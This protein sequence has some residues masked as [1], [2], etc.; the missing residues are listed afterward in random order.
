MDRDYLSSPDFNFD[1]IN[2]ASKACGPL[3]SW[4]LAQMRYSTLLN[5]VDPLRQEIKEL[6]KNAEVKQ[7]EA[8]DLAEKV[9]VL[10]DQ[11]AQYK[12]DYSKLMAK[13][14]ELK[15]EME[16]VQVSI[17][18]AKQ[19]VN[20]LSGEHERWEK[21]SASFTE[22]IATVVGDSLISAGF[23][24]YLG[25]YNH[26]FRE[27]LVTRWR[28][29][30]GELGID[31]DPRLQLIQ[32]LSSP[33]QRLHW[34]QAELP[35][36]SLCVENAI[37]LS[38]FNRYPLLVDPAGQGSQFLLQNPRENKIIRTSF[39]DGTFLKNLESSM[40]FG[41]ALLIDDVESLDPILNPVLNRE[42]QKVGGRQLVK[43]ADKDI[44]FNP[45]FSIFLC[46][47]DPFCD[48]TPDLC[49]RVTFVNFA[50]T[51]ASL[52]SQCLSKILRAE[53]PAVDKTRTDQLKLQGEFKVRLRELED[54]LLDALNSIAGNILDDENV[55]TTLE[56][57]KSESEKIKVMAEETEE[58]LERVEETC[59]LYQP[60]ARACSKLYFTLD[61]L[62]KVHFLYQ[63]SLSQFLDIVDY[64]LKEANNLD[65][66]NAMDASVR[67]DR[68]ERL[69]PLLKAL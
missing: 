55:M 30:L 11:I 58:A 5:K 53:A 40:R 18:R 52:Q 41:N 69:T 39:L 8:K 24:T 13:Q 33:T 44:D 27:I 45:L 4:C 36:D 34:K 3:C 47:R 37:I 17:G 16:A 10:E 29:I 14:M 12:L 31:T 15:Q 25:F 42:I 56:T 20:N 51:P 6:T 57:L 66:I 1:T 60:F 62:S 43:L 32:Y 38:R 7:Q 61:K 64:I 22:Q 2:K 67:D 23:L 21:Q 49:S 63:F 9:A 26:T 54:Q 35:E 19:L 68:F 48:F 59:V 46:T 50:M 28:S 65:E